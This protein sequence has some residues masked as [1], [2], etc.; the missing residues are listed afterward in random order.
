MRTTEVFLVLS[1]GRQRV[2]GFRVAVA[3]PRLGLSHG[4]L[5][6]NYG[7]LQAYCPLDVLCIPPAQTLSW[8]V[9]EGISESA[10]EGRLLSRIASDIP[11]SEAMGVGLWYFGR[12]P[13]LERL[14]RSASQ[15]NSE[16]EFAEAMAQS[17]ALNQLLGVQP[18]LPG[19]LVALATQLSVR[20]PGFSSLQWRA[21]LDFALSFSF[22]LP[23]PTRL[24]WQQ[25]GE[26][27]IPV[28]GSP[29]L[30]DIKLIDLVRKMP[31][32]TTFPV[33]AGAIG[34]SALLVQGDYATAWPVT[35]SGAGISLV[36]LGTESL[37]SRLASRTNPIQPA[38]AT[39]RPRRRRT[40]PKPQ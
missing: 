32:A 35:I 10:G 1:S 6:E 5:Q 15:I 36:I 2:K 19:Y 33:T 13:F 7:P 37:I 9:W 23:E 34:S 24:L 22:P 17:I 11:F 40:S 4:T 25:I 18:T 26:Y 16:P 20:Q 12:V 38:K 27:K 14:Q 3:Y 29:D 30:W 31:G 39:G 8:P 28:P 21:W